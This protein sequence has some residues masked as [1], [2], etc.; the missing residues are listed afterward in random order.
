MQQSCAITK[1]RISNFDPNT[2]K[3][4]VCGSCGEVFSEAYIA[5][6]SNDG[7]CPSCGGELQP[8]SKETTAQH[9]WKEIQKMFTGM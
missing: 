6:A 8:I 2:Q 7:D 9:F 5:F 1:E 4:V 3:Q